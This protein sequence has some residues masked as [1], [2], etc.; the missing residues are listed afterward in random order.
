MSLA[1]IIASGR[2]VPRVLQRIT[3]TT[4]DC[5][6]II[7]ILDMLGLF[8]T[9]C[10]TYQLGGMSEGDGPEPSDASRIRLKKV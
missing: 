1:I 9:D 6:L 2:L 7:S 8:I 10:M 5:F 3:P 4:S